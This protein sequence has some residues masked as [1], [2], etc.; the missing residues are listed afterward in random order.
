[1]TP[2]RS[3]TPD[4]VLLTID[5]LGDEDPA[6][7]AHPTLPAVFVFN[8]PALEKLQLSARR[9]GFYL[10]T[11]QDLANRREVVVLLGDPYDYAAQHDVAVTYAPVPSFQKFTRLAE[12]Y[13]YPW[14]RPPH[15]GAVRSFSAW[16]K[17]LERSGS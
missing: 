17:V 15:G 11:L 13:P 6:L 9:L 3:R 2:V 14:L 16:R 1:V 5:S 7:A 4:R 8:A 10:Q 12:I